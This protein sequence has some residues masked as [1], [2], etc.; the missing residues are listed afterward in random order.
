MYINCSKETVSHS[1][2]ALKQFHERWN[3]L[4]QFKSAETVS[5][6]SRAL[7]QFHTAQERWNSFTRFKNAETVSHSSRAL[8]QFHTV[9]ERWNSFTR[10]KSAETNLNLQ[11]L[12]DK[13]ITYVNSRR[14]ELFTD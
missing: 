5:H 12:F 13:K 1:S 3:S 2:E 8:K 11:F 7:K 10:F 6:G 4:A 14:R 9:Q